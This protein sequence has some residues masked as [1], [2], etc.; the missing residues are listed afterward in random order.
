MLRKF[1]ACYDKVI[2]D[3]CDNKMKKKINTYGH[4][5]QEDAL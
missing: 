2:I 3:G 1:I 4:A 5:T